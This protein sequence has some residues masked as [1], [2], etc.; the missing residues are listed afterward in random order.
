MVS[1]TFYAEPGTVVSITWEPGAVSNKERFYRNLQHRL[2]ERLMS[3]WG[4]KNALAYTLSGKPFLRDGR[5]ISISHAGKAAG[6]VI[7]PRPAGIDIEYRI[8]QVQAVL[9]R[10]A[11]REELMHASTPQ[12]ALWLWNAKEA[13]YKA[14]GETIRS[15]R[16]DIYIHL[17]EA[18]PVRAFV[19]SKRNEV[20]R[21]LP[22]RFAI[23]SGILALK[24]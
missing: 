20:F 8:S 5:H 11:C 23:Y 18:R 7:S 12:A 9:P 10:I 1:F 4:L 16:D 21:L 3:Q 13:V 14:A 6:I 15:W 22:F 2:K 17:E 19:R 24:D